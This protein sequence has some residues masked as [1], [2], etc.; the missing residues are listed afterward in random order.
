MNIPQKLSRFISASMFLLVAVFLA[1]CIF[2]RPVYTESRRPILPLPKIAPLNEIPNTL[3]EDRAQAQAAYN[4][5]SVNVV[6]LIEYAEALEA[7]IKQYND[8]SE[9]LN[10]KNGYTAPEEPAKAP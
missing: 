1:G 6:R 3:P 10:K 4:T 7:V 9:K 2:T 8:E 5:A